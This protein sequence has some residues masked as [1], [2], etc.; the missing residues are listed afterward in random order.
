MQTRAHDGARLLLDPDFVI[1][2]LL[3]VIVMV[4]VMRARSLDCIDGN[5]D[6]CCDFES[7]ND[8]SL[9]EGRSRHSDPKMETAPSRCGCETEELKF[10]R[11]L[12]CELYRLPLWP[13]FLPPI[14]G[15][16]FSKA[17]LNFSPIGERNI[18]L[19]A[20][21]SGRRDGIADGGGG[22]RGKESRARRESIC[23]SD[24][25]PALFSTFGHSQPSFCRL[26][27]SLF[28]SFFLSSLPS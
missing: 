27:A 22:G 14:G 25:R 23:T 19:P 24:T 13:S 12:S 4:I 8:L 10:I 6:R 5:F 21:T 11:S 1:L 17:A 28:L 16:V 7:R 18:S 2:S 15:R 9:S 3:S 26:S 20:L